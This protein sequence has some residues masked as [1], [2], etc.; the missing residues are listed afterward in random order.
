MTYNRVSAPEDYGDTPLAHAFAYSK[1][2]HWLMALCVAEQ[3]RWDTLARTGDGK[4]E[5]YNFRI[6]KD[7]AVV[8]GGYELEDVDE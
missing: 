2:S 6:T 1:E 4:T 5:M 3:A 8:E 7:V